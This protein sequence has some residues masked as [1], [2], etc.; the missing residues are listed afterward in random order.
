MFST[1][2]G[3]P[4]I[5]SFLCRPKKTHVK[6]AEGVKI[7]RVSTTLSKGKSKVHFKQGRHAASQHLHFF[8][9]LVTK[10]LRTLLVCGMILVTSHKLGV[11]LR[12]KW[13]TLMN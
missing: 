5:C 3:L 2:T 13:H 8:Q 9:I 11:P 1:Q 4:F 12:K 6:E 10:Q 7:V